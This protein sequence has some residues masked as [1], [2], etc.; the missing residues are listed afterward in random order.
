MSDLFQFPDMPLERKQMV[1][2][3]TPVPKQDD[4]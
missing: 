1:L 3:R 2:F 4:K